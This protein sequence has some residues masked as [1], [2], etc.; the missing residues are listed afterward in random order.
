MKL[1]IPWTGKQNKTALQSVG[2][3]EMPLWLQM[4]K[5][6]SHHSF[7]KRDAVL[8]SVTERI[9]PAFKTIDYTR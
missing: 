5:Q 8:F 3:L 7:K 6:S 2:N 1:E 4:K 9:S